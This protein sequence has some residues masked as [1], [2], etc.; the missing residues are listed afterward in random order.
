T[1]NISVNPDVRVEGAVT[2]EGSISTKV[3][4]DIVYDETAA[5]RFSSG[6]LCTPGGG[7]VADHY[8]LSFSTPQFSCEPIPVAIRA[9]ADA[10]CSSTVAVNQTLSLTPAGRWLG[11]GTVTFAGTDT[12]TAHLKRIPGT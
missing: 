10:T 5:Q 2:A 9:C 11:N 3:K 12:V 4:D 1:K 8:R 7:T 6:D